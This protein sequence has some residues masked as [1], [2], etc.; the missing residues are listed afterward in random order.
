[1]EEASKTIAHQIGGIQNDVLRF[2]LPG[3]KSDIVG[4]HPLESSLQFVRGVE[5][6]MKRQC[7]VNLYGAAFPLKEELDRQILSRMYY[8]GFELISEFASVPN[9]GGLP[10]LILALLIAG[11]IN[12]I[13]RD[14]ALRELGQLEQ[15][16]VFGDAA[17]KD[18]INFLRTKQNTTPE[19]KLRLLMIYASVYPEKF[20][21]DKGLQ[22]MQLAKLS[23]D[24]MKV[25][26]NMQ[27]LAGSSTKKA[28]AAAGAF[29]LKFSNQKTTQAARKDRTDEE[30]ETWSLFRFY[31]VVEVR[32]KIMQAFHF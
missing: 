13:I 23:P 17:A 29:S 12:T 22:L 4:S 5:E 27:L 19:Y 14:A 28:S 10:R 24:D 2:G 26:S 11:K 7:K 31:P 3:V 30:E 20:E 1:M 8:L 25:I 18:V 32:L 15:D 21:G 6:A 16:L 9:W